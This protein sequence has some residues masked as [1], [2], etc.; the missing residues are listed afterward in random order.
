MCSRNDNGGPVISTLPLIELTLED[1]KRIFPEDFVKRLQRWKFCGI[2]GDPCVAH[3]LKEIC[4]WLVNLN[5]DMRVSVHTNG[6]IRRP[7]WWADLARILGKNGLVVWGLDGLRDTNHL[8][9]KNTDW[10]VIMNNVAAFHS[11]GGRSIWQFIPFAHNEHQIEKAKELAAKLGFESFRTKRSRRVFNPS[12]PSEHHGTDVVD[13]K[14]KEVTHRVEPPKQVKNQNTMMTKGQ[15]LID[16]FGGIEDYIQR[17]PISCIAK[18]QKEIYV[19]ADGL[20]YP[21]CWLATI[22]NTNDF[23][24]RLTEW[25]GTHLIDP[26]KSSLKEVIEGSIFQNISASWKSDNRIPKCASMCGLT[27]SININF[28]YIKLGN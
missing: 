1:C 21:C 2:Y 27:K 10:D 25:G 9:R 17:T 3:D 26:R 6:S 24:G 4:E 15:P 16:A 20:T 7:E 13:R 23:M 28:D 19:A 22:Y 18:G 11:S 12:A 14:T 5:P 8:Y